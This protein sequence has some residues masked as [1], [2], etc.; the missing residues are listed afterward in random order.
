MTSRKEES[1]AAMAAKRDTDMF[2]RIVPSMLPDWDDAG[3]DEEASTYLL[4]DQRGPEPVPD[5]VITEDAARQQDMGVL[6]SGKEADVHLVERR[7]GS[8][9][10]ALAAKRYRGF[11]DRLF[12]ND[13]RYRT[14]RRTGNSRIDR[15]MAKGST[16]GLAFRARQWVATEF[17]VLC[18]LWSAGVAVPYPVQLMG[19]EIML[20]LIGS[21]DQVA[22][23]LV[24]ADIT[25]D[26]VR[27]LWPQ[28]VDNLRL[29]ARAGVVHGDLSAY[30]VLLD[31]QRPVFIDF[32][33]SVDPVAHPEGLSLLER[34]VLN[35]TTWFNKRGIGIDASQLVAD[36]MAEVLRS[37][38]RA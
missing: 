15:A 9:L 22:P 1:R 37:R 8:A 19:N 14:A 6:K 25:A 21:P 20:E 32:P 3:L 11:E 33:Q 29:M 4:A 12:R 7:L 18:R 38:G 16:A 23:R 34:D 30:N 17:E 5:W 31:G 36:L 27:Q 28:I 26:Q 10:N 24:Q 35:I 2:Q 13:A